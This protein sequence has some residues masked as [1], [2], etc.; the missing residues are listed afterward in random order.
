M[1]RAAYLALLAHARRL[2]RDAED[3]RDLVQDTLLA[4]VEQGRACDRED[5]AWLAAVLRRQAAL[6]V[7]GQV[8]RRRRERW[9]AT[10]PLAEPAGPAET[11]GPA[12][13][14]TALG[15]LPPASRQV[16]VLAL[17]GLDA[18]EIRW[19]LRLDAAA[20]RQRLARLRR[21]LAALEPAARADLAEAARRGPLRGGLACG[22]LRRALKA[23]L[24]GPALGTHD[25][26]G[27]LLVLRG[28]G[29]A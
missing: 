20:F 1:D 28:R 21:A 3:A 10:A 29:H 27:H 17:H 2:T 25:P 6:R 23:A 11:A 18:G 12:P 14:T 9:A 5:A 19:I 16:A 24:R 26:D 22:P 4:A 7:R 15:R 8:R 13:D